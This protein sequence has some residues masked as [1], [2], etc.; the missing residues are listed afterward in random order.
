ML[1]KVKFKGGYFNDETE[2]ELFVNDDRLSL[3]YGKNGSG[4]S[5][6]SKVVSKATGIPVEEI[7]YATLYDQEDR[8]YTDVQSIHVFNEDYI[9]SRVKLRE[10]GLDTIVLLGELGDLED[11]ILD[12]HNNFHHTQ[13]L[14]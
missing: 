14:Q 13:A 4:K 2:L 8:A 11:K 9:N 7:A 3:L 12:F 1:K 10:D 5:T 6:I